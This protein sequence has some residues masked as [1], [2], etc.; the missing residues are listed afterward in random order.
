MVQGEEVMSRWAG[1][2]VYLPTGR[3]LGTVYDAVIDTNT[4]HCTHLFIRDTPEDLVEGNLHVA[5]PWRWVRAIDEVVLL[6]W[7]PPTPIPMNS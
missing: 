4:L 3:K 7:F 6:R 2:E 1:L 5:V